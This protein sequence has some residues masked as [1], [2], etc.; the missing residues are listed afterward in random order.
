MW[1]CTCEE[2]LKVVVSL[3][4][5]TWTC[6]Q[7]EMVTNSS[8]INY[9]LRSSENQKDFPLEI[10]RKKFYL[11]IDTGIKKQSIQNT[12]PSGPLHMCSESHSRKD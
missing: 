10:H 2:Y 8:S 9:G 6:L 3:V 1:F 12:Q 7:E 5:P 4:S 11:R